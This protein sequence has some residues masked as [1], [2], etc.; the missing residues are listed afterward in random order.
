MTDLD[1]WAKVND[2]TRSEGL[3]RLVEIGLKASQPVDTTR[4]RPNQRGEGEIGDPSAPPEER[5][6]RRLRL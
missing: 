6:Q 5:A 1:A 3:R 2:V 4:N